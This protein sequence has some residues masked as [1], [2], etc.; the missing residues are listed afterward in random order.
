MIKVNQFLTNCIPM[1]YFF[2]YW[3]LCRVLLNNCDYSQFVLLYLFISFL[4]TWLPLMRSFQFFLFASNLIAP[5]NSI[6]SFYMSSSPVFHHPHFLIYVNLAFL[7]F[8]HFTRCL[9][10]LSSFNFLFL[11]EFFAPYFIKVQHMHNLS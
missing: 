11:S 8:Y 6:F 4:S 7:Y 3:W 5:L 2:I 9:H 1:N 10:Q